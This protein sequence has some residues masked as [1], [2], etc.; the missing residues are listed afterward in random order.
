MSKNKLPQGVRKYIRRQKM[1]IR[2]KAKTEAEEKQ[3]VSE[4]LNKYYTPVKK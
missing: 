4:L 1:L 3:L 2:A